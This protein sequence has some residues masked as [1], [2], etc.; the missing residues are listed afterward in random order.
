MQRLT[1]ALISVFPSSLLFFGCVDSF[2]KSCAV[3]YCVSM[4]RTKKL[5]RCDKNLV[6]HLELDCDDFSGDSQAAQVSHVL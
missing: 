2:D 6:F 3:S 4:C 1:F 5:T